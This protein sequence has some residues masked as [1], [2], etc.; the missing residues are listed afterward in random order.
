MNNI[1]KKLFQ[2][3][4]EHSLP[5]I[6]HFLNT[7]ELTTIKVEKQLKY[8][9]IDFYQSQAIKTYPYYKPISKIITSASY[10]K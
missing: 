10:R 5:L 9:A 2:E 7:K 6:A 3:E 1:N 8:V 4:Q